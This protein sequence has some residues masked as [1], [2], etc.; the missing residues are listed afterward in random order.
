MRGNAGRLFGGRDDAPGGGGG[1]VGDDGG[2]GAE[3]PKRS[4]LPR[5]SSLTPFGKRGS[6]DDLE[7]AGPG[8]AAGARPRRP[9]TVRSCRI[10]AQSPRPLP[11]ANV[12]SQGTASLCPGNH[13]QFIC[14]VWSASMLGEVK[15][16]N[17]QTGV[18]PW[19]KG[20]G[21]VPGAAAGA[22][23]PAKKSR[24][25][26]MMGSGASGEG[27]GDEEWDDGRG[28]F[29]RLRVNQQAIEESRGA[30]G[31]GKGTAAGG[32]HE[33]GVHSFTTQLNV[34]DF[35]WDRG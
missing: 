22:A 28:A 29:G 12:L 6:S 34:S 30:V 17:G 11:C 20:S 16:G 24:L 7:K 25:A 2:G 15:H 1:G 21:V 18:R 14:L 3:S 5:L 26:W 9:L 19:E 8:P 27:D 35:V 31:A 33:A 32:W 10:R 23:P 4:R 13:W